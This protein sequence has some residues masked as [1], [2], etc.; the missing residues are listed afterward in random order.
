M[1][2]SYLGHAGDD[3]EGLESCKDRTISCH[4]DH[5]RIPRDWRIRRHAISSQIRI[6]S[7]T[8]CR[9]IGMD[10]TDEMDAIVLQN[11]NHGSLRF[12]RKQTAFRS[13]TQPRAR[14]LGWDTLGT[15]LGYVLLTAVQLSHTGDTLTLEGTDSNMRCHKE[16][17]LISEVPYPSICTAVHHNTIQR[18]PTRSQR[19]ITR[20]RSPLLN[21]NTDATQTTNS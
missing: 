12:A 15:I 17:S 7:L 8:A 4:V 3:H 16:M 10:E 20:R 9:F 14:R 11:A 6:S 13:V 21:S 18:S 5:P 1:E 2:P 19:I